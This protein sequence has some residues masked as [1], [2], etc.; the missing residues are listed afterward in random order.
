MII[1]GLI[2]SLLWQL[3]LPNRNF[4]TVLS[5]VRRII[6][7][8]FVAVQLNDGCKKMLQVIKKCIFGAIVLT[9]SAT[10]GFQFGNSKICTIIRKF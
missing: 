4:E 5:G 7:I 8:I 2:S 3:T 6:V 1:I 9:E 10:F